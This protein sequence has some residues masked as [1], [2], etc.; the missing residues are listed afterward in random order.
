MLTHRLFTAPANVALL[1]LL[2]G[3]APLAAQPQTQPLLAPTRDVDITYD[4]TRPHR[5]R[6]RERVR[7]LASE[8]L[9]RIDGPDRS[10]TII[11]RKGNEITLLVPATR[12]Y[13]KLEGRPRWPM[14][15]EADAVLSRVGE[16]VVAGQRCVEWSWVEDS[17]THTLC[18]TAD[19]VALQ[20][21][22]NGKAVM[23]ARSVSYGRQNAALFKAPANYSPALAPEGGAAP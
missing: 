16:A 5:A 12:T 23:V 14:E 21:S 4:V 7:W 15:P 1:A 22:V 11:D 13:R 20:L 17:D 3:G 8:H 9:Q 18:A 19:G 10:V 6:I 2:L